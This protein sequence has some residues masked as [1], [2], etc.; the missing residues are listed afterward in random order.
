MIQYYLKM[1]WRNFSSNKLFSFLNLIGLSIAIAICIPLFLFVCKEYSF[2]N[3]FSNKNQIY[4]VN[5]VTHDD[6]PATWAHV[7]NAVAPALMRD[8]PEVR[9]AARMLKNGFGTP[10][11]LRVGQ[12]NYKEDLLY[13]SDPE[14]F[15]IFD[16]K[17][18]AGDRQNPLSDNNSVAINES[19]AKRLFGDKNPIGQSILVDNKTQLVVN[20]VYKDLPDNSSIDPALIANFKSN[21]LSKRVYWSNASYETFC[22]LRKGANADAVAK[23]LPELIK[24]YVKTEDD[25]WFDLALQPLSDVH[26]HSAHISD[27][28][29]SSVGDIKT[30]RQLSLLGLL[31][32]VIACIN[33][34]NLATA[35]S[36]KRAREVGINKTLGATRFQMVGRFYADTALTVLLAVIVGFVLSFGSLFLFNAISDSHL[37]ISELLSRRALLFL[38]VIWL[39]VTVLAGSYPAM[40]LSRSSALQLMQKRLAIGGM[41]RLLRK[42]LVVIQFSC[43]IIL[44]IAVVI[45]YQQMKFIG[46]KNL[47]FNASGVMMINISG[48][49]EKQ[50]L[51][52]LSNSL[53]QIPAVQEVSELQSP[54]GFSASL[55]S[56]RKADEKSGPALY[57]CYADAAVVPALGLQLLAG[58]TLPDHLSKTDSMVYVLV[59]KKVVDYLGWTPQEAIGKKVNVELG[60]NAYIV[61]VVGD[62]NYMSLKRPIEPYVY[63]AMNDAPESK[64]AMIVKVSTDQL[65]A[66]MDKIKAAFMKNVPSAAFDYAFLDSHLASLYNTEKVVQKTVLL[67]SALAIFVS[68]LGLF[69]LSAFMAEQKTKEIGIRKVLGASNFSIGSMLS[70][71]FL[72]LVLLSIVIGIPLAIYMMQ[73]WLTHF[74]YRISISW[75]VVALAAIAGLLIAFITI[76]Y[77][78]VKAARSNP[79][80]SIK[81]E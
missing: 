14:L 25:R 58:K 30:V 31:I 80:K 22:L 35:K 43:S 2:D 32:V 37:H 79:L 34:M 4:R 61:G 41:D 10:A 72:K 54:P 56:L 62:F 6:S 28:Y 20:A 48:V 77:Q 18:V 17:F 69:G 42:T 7:P 47:G 8:I 19:E 38:V 24:K 68:C 15:K 16:F 52:S 36:E 59:N 78:S 73:K 1:A 33:Y 67:F 76:S 64:N 3:L 51:E 65:M 55:R 23:K 26:L 53:R 75:V 63:Y 74:E 12:Q 13:W 81:T 39:I 21:R 11:S 45:I 50:N 5:L 29:I 40:L 9:Y 57:T 66:T 49:R 44:I 60:D 70:V 71:D 46:N 27:T